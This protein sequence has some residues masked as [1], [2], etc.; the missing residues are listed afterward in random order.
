MILGLFPELLPAGGVQRICRHAAAVLYRYAEERG[1]RCTLLS[2]NDPEGHRT[3]RVG[4]AE[5]PFE[6]FGRKKVRFA[7]TVLAAGHRIVLFGHPNLAILGPA[8]RLR[9]GGARQL[10]L[11]YGFEVWRPLG[12]MRQRGL[13]GADTIIAPSR[14]T[15]ENMVK[16]NKA[17][18]SKRVAVIPPALDPDF[19]QWDGVGSDAPADAPSGNFLLTV[20]R[21]ASTERYKGVD[22]VLRALPAVRNCHPEV[23]YFIVGDGDDRPR[24]ERLSEE[25][26]LGHCVTF[27]GEKVGDEL[28]KYYEACA[29]YVMPSR[30]E[31]FGVAFLEAMACGKPVI[32]G[33]HGGTP[34]AIDDGV[35]GYLV[36]HDDTKAISDRLNHLLAEEGLRREFGAA[37][38]R[39]VESTFGFQH[40]QARLIDLLRE[41]RG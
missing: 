9:R 8:M 30:A 18:G 5:F 40:F 2:L 33:A 17:L 1:E 4:D 19:A 25:L 10:V 29:V 31:G 12:W 7:M 41:D 27:A 22:S 6:G 28:L 20:A 11:T 39:K 35:T 34:E 32:G 37:G 15:W 26:G 36:R 38:R 3:V 24:L 16:A 23:R 14:F 21:L 13:A